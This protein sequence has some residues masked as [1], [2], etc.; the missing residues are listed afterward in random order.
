MTEVM[1]EGIHCRITEAGHG[2]I[3]RG[4]LRRLF[5]ML[6]WIYFFCFNDEGVIAV[7]NCAGQHQCFLYLVYDS[8]GSRSVC[9]KAANV[10]V[11]S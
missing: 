2:W 8:A 9:I 5:R 3:I 11:F 6:F 1:T 10:V 4:L 7:R